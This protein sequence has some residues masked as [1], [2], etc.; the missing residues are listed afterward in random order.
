MERDEIARLVGASINN[1][2]NYNKT[3]DALEWNDQFH[4]AKHNGKYTELLACYVDSY[5]NSWESK[6]SSR[7]CMFCVCVVILIMV[8]AVSLF[9]VGSAAVYAFW[10]HGDFVSIIPAVSGAVVALVGGFMTIPDIIAK[11]L[12]NADEEKYLADIIGK[13][14]EYDSRIR[15][16][17]K[18][19]D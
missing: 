6:N 10:S 15:A 19:S 18:E 12:Y 17:K 13:I 1:L 4:L 8:S 14:Q 9:V 7:K 5:K 11:Y 16:G 3:D 2:S